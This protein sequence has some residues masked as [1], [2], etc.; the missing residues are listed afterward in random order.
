MLAF[1]TDINPN[2]R[3][4]L[5]HEE[6][7]EC[8]TLKSIFE[9]KKKELGLTQ[10][11]VADA[12]GI[13]QA[14]VSQ[15]FNARRALNL[16][17]A[18]TCAQLLKVDIGDF[19]KR[20]KR[21][22]LAISLVAMQDKK[23]TDLP[24]FELEAGQDVVVYS[25]AQLISKNNEQG[26]ATMRYAGDMSGFTQ[27]LRMDN[28]SMN[29]TGLPAPRGSVLK[30]STDSKPKTGEYAVFIANQSIAVGEYTLIAGRPHVRPTNPQY[31]MIDVTDAELVG[32]VEES[33][34][35]AR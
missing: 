11:A 7:R 14:T 16:R 15:Y 28:D 13:T 6:Q 30:I 19:S 34:I 27:F 4:E 9:S 22:A 12:L 1:M 32:V 21:E 26:S 29:G 2:E 23:N 25:F 18:K 17:T 24:L 20:L 33:I 35:K 5:T 8:A 3:R 10:Q 31:P